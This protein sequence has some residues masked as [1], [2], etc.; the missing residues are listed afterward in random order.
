MVAPVGDE[1][2]RHDPEQPVVPPHVGAPPGAQR[3]AEL[4]PQEHVLHHE[5]LPTPKGDEP[6]A[7]EE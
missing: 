6:S 7:D 5:G 2:S 3:D 4:L 1:A